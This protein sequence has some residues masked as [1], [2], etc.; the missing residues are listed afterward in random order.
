MR[1]ITTTA[2]IVAAYAAVAVLS[3]LQLAAQRE[4]GSKAAASLKTAWGH[5]DLQGVWD[6]S[7]NTPLQRP[8][9]LKNKAVLTE[10]EA[11]QLL[12]KS[13]A[14]RARQ[15]NSAAREGD[16]GTYNRFWTDAPR[17]INRQTSLII[18]P[19]DGRLPA[20]T[21]AA[22]KWYEDT[23]EARKGIDADA[24]T[25]GGFVEDLGPRGLFVRCIVGFN[26]GPPINPQSYNQNVQIFQSRDH[27]AL[28][29]EMVHNTRVIPLDGRPAVSDRIRQY[30]G[31]SRARWEGH[32]L[33]IDTTNFGKEVYDPAY[34]GGGMRPNL[35]GT[36]KLTERL[37]RTG[38]DELVY[39]YTI[40]DPSWYTAP[41]TAR[42]PMTKNPEPLYEFACHEA[43]YSMK[44]ILEGARL[45]EKD[46]A[47]KSSR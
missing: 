34:S 38:T 8:P 4:G 42:I 18:E 39:Q 35:N 24:P 17:A 3:S 2:A 32:A 16:T 44:A 31:Q 5:P 23:R 9:E 14:Q 43:N 45:S 13:L 28:L 25:P 36:Y 15:D 21:P 30:N 26:A 40:N 46:A 29:H 33:V 27:V 37:T 41:L 10:A 7:S 6:F 19:A 47:K 22:Q 11:E 12:Q 1:G 20:Y